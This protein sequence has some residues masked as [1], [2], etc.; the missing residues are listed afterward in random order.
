MLPMLTQITIFGVLLDC[1]ATSKTIC[2]HFAGKDHLNKGR[3]TFVRV[4][5]GIYFGDYW[6]ESTIILLIVVPRAYKC[7]AENREGSPECAELS[8]MAM[9]P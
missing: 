5:F 6:V 9:L 1:L 3:P 2:G 7:F 8:A 4:Y